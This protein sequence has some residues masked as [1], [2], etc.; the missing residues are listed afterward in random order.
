MVPVRG[1]PVV[2]APPPLLKTRVVKGSGLG[3]GTPALL[4]AWGYAGL[5]AAPL[6]T[7]HGFKRTDSVGWAVA[8][9]TFGAFFPFFAVPIALAQGFGEPKKRRS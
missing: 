3:N 9:S 2:K 5:V 8:W 4:K 6:L 7:Y 1:G